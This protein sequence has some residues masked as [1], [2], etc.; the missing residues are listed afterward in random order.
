M[1]TFWPTACTPLRGLL[2][3]PQ[4][5]GKVG[6]V[7]VGGFTSPRV[8]SPT[9]GAPSSRGMAGPSASHPQLQDSDAKYDDIMSVSFQFYICLILRIKQYDSQDTYFK[10]HTRVT[11]IHNSS[12]ARQDWNIYTLYC[13]SLLLISVR[14]V[15]P[16]LAIRV[17]DSISMAYIYSSWKNVRTH[18]RKGASYVAISVPLGFC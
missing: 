4:K 17:Y 15:T 3:L 13:Y 5:L 2:C 1:N 8:M 10:Y 7:I 12:T 6:G 9:L 11:L 18:W 14:D 16:S